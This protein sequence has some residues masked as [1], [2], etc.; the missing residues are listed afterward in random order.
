MKLNIKKK[1]SIFFHRKSEKNLKLFQV[2]GY[3]APTCA[4]CSETIV[5]NHSQEATL[6]FFQQ[7][8]QISA[9]I[10]QQQAM[11]PPPP[12]SIQQVSFS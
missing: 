4:K 1:F 3:H 5:G 9:T 2:I 11:P 6:S 8:P 7:P 10:Q 12:T